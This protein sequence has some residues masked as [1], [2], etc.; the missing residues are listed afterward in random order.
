MTLITLHE[1]STFIPIFFGLH[2]QTKV[3]R[4]YRIYSINLDTNDMPRQ[5]HWPLSQDCNKKNG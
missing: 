4:V 2:I 5:I 3:D 1:I